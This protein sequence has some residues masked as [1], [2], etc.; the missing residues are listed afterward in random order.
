M[1]LI[2]EDNH[3]HETKDH[4]EQA[5]LKPMNCPGHCLT[6]KHEA[7]SYRDLPIRYSD[8]SSLH[9][10]EPKGTLTGLTR[11]RRFHQD[12]GH[13]FCRMDQIEQELNSV[14]SMVEHIYRNILKF[15]Y[16]IVI[17]TRPDD[18]MGNILEWEAAEKA[19]LSTVTRLGIPYQIN[20]K[21]GAF[22]GPKIDCIITDALKREHQCATIQLDFQLPQ[23]F[24]LIYTDAHGNL[25][26]PVIIHRAILGSFERMLALLVEHFGGKWPLWLSP[27]QVAICPISDKHT[28]F[29]EFVE[30][31]LKNKGYFVEMY[32]GDVGLAKKVRLA[33]QDQ[34]NIIL[35]LGDTE[36]KDRTVS[37]R[38]RDGSQMGNMSVDALMEY[39]QQEIMR[40][41]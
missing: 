17:S 31:A 37:V 28:A 27:R 29:A 41:E 16:K 21:D 19:L 5:G 30:S 20:A 14:L 22:Y 3:K 34:C 23:R 9:R 39:L 40:F 4:E 33:Q 2:G 36:T 1:F 6:F 15:D 26:H 11:V 10:N 12:D 24:N 7:Y 32:I 25:V 8:F 38:K 13:I 35:V 18:F